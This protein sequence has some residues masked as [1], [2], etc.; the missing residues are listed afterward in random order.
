MLLCWQII[1]LQIFIHINIVQL[2]FF[3]Y[4]IISH[5]AYIYISKMNKHM[6][7]WT[8]SITTI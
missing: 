4:L 1:N 3:Y 6:S 7:L 2:V 5:S 8:M